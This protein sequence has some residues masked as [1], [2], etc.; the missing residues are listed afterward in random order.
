MHRVFLVVLFVAALGA[1]CKKSGTTTSPSSTTTS[2]AAAPTA[3]DTFN[4]RLDVGG[5]LFF[6]FTVGV[7]GT[8]N[9]SVA[10]IG[11]A[12]VPATVQT[13]LGIGTISDT[14]C[15]NTIAALAKPGV[16]GVTASENPGDYCAS[17]ADVGNLFAPASFT[18]TVDHP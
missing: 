15:S 9:V 8:V 4:G 13:R 11:G 3:T 7:Y 17:I 12:G 14:G 1:G 16:V 6:K 18:L 10:S 5:S 2:T